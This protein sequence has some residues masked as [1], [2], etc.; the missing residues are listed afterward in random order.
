MVINWFTTTFVYYGPKGSLEFGAGHVTYVIQDE[1]DDSKDVTERDRASVMNV[2][3][4]KFVNVCLIISGK[5]M[6]T[7]SLKHLCYQSY[8]TITSHG[9][10]TPLLC[11]QG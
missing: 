1:V 2:F 8:Q 4:G 6:K 9:W 11:G 10:N 7:S 5:V 3:N